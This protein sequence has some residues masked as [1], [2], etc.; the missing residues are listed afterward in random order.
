MHLFNAVVSKG[1]MISS[2]HSLWLRLISP[3]TFW[4]NVLLLFKLK[5]AAVPLF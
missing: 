2:K 5:V 3:Q 1:N 4:L